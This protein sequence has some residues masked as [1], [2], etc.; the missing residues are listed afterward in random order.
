M[1]Y[2]S[3]VELNPY[4]RET[5]TAMNSP[6]IMHAAVMASFVSTEPQ[7]G[8]RVLWRIDHIGSSVFLLIQSGSKPDLHHIVDQFGRPDTGQTGDT[9]DYRPFLD[10]IQKGKKYRFRIR[11]NP[12]R[13]I[14]TDGK[15]GKVKAHVTTAQ[16][17]E[18]LLSR[19]EKCGFT[20]VSDENR[21]KIDVTNRSFMKFDHGNST[22]SIATATFEGILEVLDRELFLDAI[23]N[24]IGKAKAYGCGMISV[25]EV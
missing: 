14:P 3:R 18:W 19:A 17:I 25:L 12:I 16:Q 24:G 5:I 13:S 22:V 6:Q 8:S 15:R 21:P 10:R 20:V 23:Q 1:T 7:Q 4:R 11:A 2:L 9:L